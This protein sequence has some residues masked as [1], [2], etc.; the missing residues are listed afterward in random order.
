M[1]VPAGG[2]WPLQLTVSE[3]RQYNTVWSPDGKWIVY[4]QD[5][6]GSEYYDLFAVPGERGRAHQPDQHARDFRERIRCSLPMARRMRLQLQAE[7]FAQ[8]RHRP[9]RLEFAAR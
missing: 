4:E 7:D 8:H 6:G 3:D 2:G 1:E 5:F 9:H